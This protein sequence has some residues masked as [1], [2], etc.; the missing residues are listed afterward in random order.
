MEEKQDYYYVYSQEFN[1]YL[2]I[3]AID[4]FTIFD[5]GKFL[6][7]TNETDSRVIVPFDF[8]YF[9]EDDVDYKV[10]HFKPDKKTQQTPFQIKLLQ[11]F[12]HEIV[13]ELWNYFNSK[14]FLNLLVDTNNLRQ[15]G[16]LKVSKDEIF[17]PFQTRFH[18]V[19]FDDFQHEDNDV[20]KDFL[21]VMIMK[22][23][24]ILN[25]RKEKPYNY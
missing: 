5:A 22:K 17:K 7:L 3:E 1:G 4:L 23:E 20:W 25:L 2:S 13:N 16:I 24:E 6:V 19:N 18:L 14:A 11:I 10:A 8:Q 21:N 15:K 12:H 9:A